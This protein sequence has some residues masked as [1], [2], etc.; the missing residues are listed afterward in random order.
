MVPGEHVHDDSGLV[1][2]I[3]RELR[4]L[5]RRVSNAHQPQEHEAVLHV[6]PLPLGHRFPHLT[7]IHS[8]ISH[9]QNSQPLLGHDLN[10]ILDAPQELIPRRN[11][12]LGAIL[13]HLVAELQDVFCAF[14]VH[15]EGVPA[16]VPVQHAHPL[17]GGAE[18]VLGHGLLELAEGGLAH[19]QLVGQDLERDL[20]GVAPHLALAGLD[21]V[22][23]VAQ[24]AALQQEPESDVGQHLL[25]AQ[26]PIANH[27]LSRGVPPVPCHREL[28]RARQPNARHGHLALREGAGFVRADVG[29]CL[30]R[31]QSDQLA[32]QRAL[33]G[34]A[35]H[36]QGHD[37]GD[38][39]DQPLGNH[40]DGE[41]DG[42]EDDVRAEVEFVHGEHDHREEERYGEQDVGH[43]VEPLLHG[44]GSRSRFGDG[45][46]D[47]PDLRVHS[48]GHGDSSAPS[49]GQRR[50]RVHHVQ[51]V[52]QR[53]IVAFDGLHGF[54]HGE[55]FSCEHGLVH[56]QVEHFDQSAVG[57]DHVAH[58]EHDDVSR[59]DAGARDPAESTVSDDF[60]CGR[61]HPSQSIHRLLGTVLLDETHCGVEDDDEGQ[62]SSF[63]VV[64]HCVRHRGSENQYHGQPVGELAQ[65]H[66]PWIHS[67]LAF[68]LVGTELRLQLSHIRFFETSVYVCLQHM[69][70]LSHGQS[71]PVHP[72][73]GNVRSV[74]PG[75]RCVGTDFSASSTLRGHKSPRIP[76]IFRSWNRTRPC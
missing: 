33:A 11:L 57:R 29:H 73:P 41:R 58:F 19:L 59:N 7:F 14:G 47:F 6:F 36:A 16:H 64:L 26:D 72:G 63:G 52:A 62:H 65:Q 3:H 66:S 32:D 39:G 38:D 43:E 53:R 17:G 15:L 21:D 46:G 18:R 20:R 49:F 68:Q 55:R 56:L 30:Q 25:A 61:S 13:D 1:A 50:A 27:N 71:V 42:V 69:C 9:D 76:I 48:R 28:I 75:S 23:G 45:L 37:D 60:G 4:L 34:H 40:S 2:L 67:P 70:H 5:P 12:H 35:P 10:L 74:H 44:S 24:G 54:G 31:L 22:G 51:A 8:P